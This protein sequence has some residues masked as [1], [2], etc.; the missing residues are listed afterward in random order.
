MV[1]ARWQSTIVDT[2]GNIQPGASVRVEAELPGS[3]LA[4]LYSDRAGTVAIGNPT[5]ADSAGYVGFHL[6]G[7]AYKI[8]ATLAGFSQTFRYVAIGRAQESDALSTGVRYRFDS[9]V[10]DADPG[11]GLFR[12]NNATLASVTS[13]FID[14]LS[15]DAVDLTA[16]L[17]SWD[18]GGASTNRG[19]ITV[20]QSGTGAFFIAT[21]TG[22]VAAPAG[23]RKVVVTPIATSGTFAVGQIT[24]LQF[25]RSGIDA[26][27]DVNGPASATADDIATYNGTTGK[28]IKD[29]GKT[30]T[31]VGAGKQTI[32]VPAAAMVPTS[33]A[34]GPTLQTIAI[35]QLTVSHLLFDPTGFESAHF[36][37][38]MPKS[39]NVGQFSFQ[40]V[41][42]HA[43][44]TVNFGVMWQ[45][46]AVSLSDTDSITTAI[47]DGASQVDTGGTTDA[48]Y[49]SPESSPFSLSSPA[50]AANDIQFFR[51]GRLAADA[52]DTLAIDARLLG[53]K[54]FYTTNANTDN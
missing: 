18:D 8:T 48:L 19:T 10:V 52:A 25:T 7:G 22:S 20:E 1:L 6:V 12:F 45:L 2:A 32:W 5:T 37:I 16:V 23:Y 34:A 46:T 9:S 11:A 40:A 51:A 54:I 50:G 47:S 39:W 49:I 33:G 43:A 14:L 26:T 28:L 15:D 44:T 13:L 21:V 35:N 38:P 41:W 30:I 4:S 36:Q 3:P 27:G 29:S 31:T 53:F 17:D 42:S 24:S